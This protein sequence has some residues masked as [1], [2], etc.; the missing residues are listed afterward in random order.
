MT[1]EALGGVTYDARQ[2]GARLAGQLHRVRKIM[3]DARWRT[4]F[5]I[6]AEIRAPESSVSARIRDLR[7]LAY[8]GYTIERRRRPDQPGTWEYRLRA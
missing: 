8:G 7:K 1:R 5:E 4:L 2:D 6:A 3:A